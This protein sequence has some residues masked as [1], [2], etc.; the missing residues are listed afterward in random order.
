MINGTN[1]TTSK[2]FTLRAETEVEPANAHAKT[3]KCGLFLASVT[4]VT[5]SRSRGNKIWMLD[6]MRQKKAFGDLAISFQFQTR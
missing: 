5:L 6:L 3:C 4:L 2:P 1:Y